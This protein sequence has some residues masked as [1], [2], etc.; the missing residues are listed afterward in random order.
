MDNLLK[1]SGYSLK[2]IEY[3]TRRLNVGKI[4]SPSVE[5]AYTGPCGDT[6][7]IYLIID[8]EI[9]VDAKFE[10]IGCAGVFSAGSALMELIKG[11]HIREAENVSS[12]DVIDHLG[13][14][15]EN[16]TDCIL[17]AGDTLKKTLQLFK[18]HKQLK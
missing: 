11:K 2:A 15:P 7:K 13:G 18:E 8:S 6:M 14:V 3:Y 10:A 1:A 4:A 5:L 9:I 12:Q 17:L 16:K